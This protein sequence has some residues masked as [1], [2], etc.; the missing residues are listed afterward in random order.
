MIEKVIDIKV[1]DKDLDKTGKKLKKV[2]KNT[3]DVEK[4]SKKVEKQNKKTTESTKELSSS[5]DKVSGGALSAFKTLKTGLLSSVKGF[6]SLKVAI[7]ATGIG[8]FITAILAVKQAFQSS[9]EGQNKFAK[10]LAVIG[11]VMGNITD[12]L[13]DL[14]EYIIS[15]FENP[16]KA[17]SDFANLIK[18]NIV[19]RFNGLL[20][21]IPKLGE[22]VGLLFEGEFSKAGKVAADA[23]GKVALGTES[24][25]DNLTKAKKALNDFTN[26]AIKDAEIAASIADQRAKADKIERKLIVERAKANQRIADLRF[27]AEQRDKFSAQERIKLLKEASKIEEDITNKEIKA[28]KIRFE[29]KKQENNLS[30]SNKK[31]LNAVAELEAKLIS[32]NTSKL[33]LQKRLEAQIQAASREDLARIKAEQKAEDDKKL[34]EEKRKQE[35]IQAD[36][37]AEIERLN[38]IK[39]IRDEFSKKNED[40]EAVSEQSKL[41]LQKSRKLKELELLKATEEQKQ[42]VIAFYNKKQEDLKIKTEQEK[43][44]ADAKAEKERQLNQLEFEE[45]QAKTNAEKLELQR[46]RLMLENDLIAQDIERKRELFLEGTQARVDAENEYALRKQQIDNQLKAN[47]DA[48]EN[49][50]VTRDKILAQQKIALANQ[51]LGAI[52]E[53][54]GQ[55]TA[56]GKA[57]ALASALIN[58]Y[59]G[60]TQVWKSEST[61][62]EPFATAQKVV[63][64]ATVLASGFK[65]VKAIKSTK[66]PSFASGGGAGG[67]VG[68]GGSVSAPSFNVVG[69]SGVNQLAQTLNQDTEPIQAYVVAN[70]VTNAQDLNNNIIETASLG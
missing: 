48:I 34:A 51:T 9:E 50:K 55:N 43:I 17:I 23:V 41:D 64:T 56:A 69:T 14:G 57:A 4:S 13:S 16:Q 22:A 1:K 31:D 49:D 11:S 45:S 60:V 37:K 61:L 2:N 6:K 21:L 47:E 12:I 70:D 26:E 25:T 32:L 42:E 68:G 7:A 3:K 52:T 29:T 54:L 53:I 24:I 38:K 35:K 58:T 44:Q 27:K 62:P 15:A 66:L 39:A 33:N 8:L 19:N 63:S 65:A 10:I 28:S 5:L 18:D 36:A 20:E 67:S 40:E 46:T 30:K 59:Q